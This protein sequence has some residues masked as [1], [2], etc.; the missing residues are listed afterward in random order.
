MMGRK[1]REQ[2]NFFFLDTN[3]YLRRLKMPY[4]PD[5]KRVT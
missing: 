4:P 3:R 1:Y 5:C 2:A